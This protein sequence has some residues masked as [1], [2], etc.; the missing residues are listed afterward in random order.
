MLPIE[1][2][3]AFDGYGCAIQG[4][5]RVEKNSIFDMIAFDLLK[6]RTGNHTG[7]GPAGRRLFLAAEGR[8]A[9]RQ[10]KMRAGASS[11]RRMA[12]RQAGLEGAL[13]RKPLAATPR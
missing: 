13:A 12:L 10:T 3:R 6:P 1:D 8:S 7:A 11:G 4:I 5:R 2:N 9:A